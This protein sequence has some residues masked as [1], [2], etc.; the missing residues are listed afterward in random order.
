MSEGKR[1]AQRKRKRG[2]R[3]DETHRPAKIIVAGM[4]GGGR[5]RALEWY[6]GRDVPDSGLRGRLTN[7]L[8]TQRQLTMSSDVQGC[9]PTLH[10]LAH[11]NLEWTN[12][13][14]N[15]YLWAFTYP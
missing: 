13:R 1:C 12:T 2:R 4:I 9:Y 10:E 14:N 15:Y 11:S 7:T 6:V 3:V 5:K 8:V